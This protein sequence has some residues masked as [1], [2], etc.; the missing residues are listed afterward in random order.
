MP[1]HPTFVLS[2]NPAVEV[3]PDFT[4]EAIVL[5]TH[6]MSGAALA[7]VEQS[8]TARRSDAA[9]LPMV[10]A[11]LVA[12]MCSGRRE[13]GLRGFSDHLKPHAA[14]LAA[15]MGV[16]SLPTAGA[17]SRYLSSLT[18]DQAMAMTTELLA[19][20]VAGTMLL[21]H[22]LT[23]MVDALGQRWRVFDLDPTVQALRQRALPEGPGLPVAHRR[24]E[25]LA[26]PGYAGRH[27]GEVIVSSGR[28]QEAGSGLWM[29][30]TL[31]AGNMALSAAITDSLGQTAQVLA[32]G[33]AE[34]LDSQ[35]LPS[36]MRLDGGGGNVPTMVQIEAARSHFLARSAQ[37]AILQ[38]ADVLAHLR[39]GGWQAV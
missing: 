36:V 18:M 38:Q 21:D 32:G 1:R 15:A 4:A 13:G 22:P 9:T 12:Y 39:G 25:T 29:S 5:F 17:V 8:G 31:G 2:S 14:K 7:A 33:H 10:L 26:D 37:Y 6:A 30:A 23:T 20:S 34:P 35:K 27:R 28:T 11:F 16:S 24:A 19:Q 3:L